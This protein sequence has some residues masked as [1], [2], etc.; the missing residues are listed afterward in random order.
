[1]AGVLV[2]GV[3]MLV[4]FFV[5]VGILTGSDVRKRC[6]M[7]EERYGGDCVEA[8]LA[9]AGDEGALYEEKNSAIWA[10][11]QLGDKRALPILEKMYTGAVPD[12]EPW[13]KMISQYELG[14]AIK[15]LRGGANIGAF[16]WR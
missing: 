14:K 15:L 9:L 8:L 16:V 1:M 11:G 7:A 4:L 13:K 10:L 3:G 2:L 12:R 6:K 5:L